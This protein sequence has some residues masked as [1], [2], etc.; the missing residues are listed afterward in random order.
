[1][2]PAP[3]SSPAKGI[4][5]LNWGDRRK[6]EDGNIY[7]PLLHVSAGQAQGPRRWGKYFCFYFSWLGMQTKSR[8]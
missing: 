4:Q 2:R 7:I 5:S 1:M 3:P 8:A 6:Q